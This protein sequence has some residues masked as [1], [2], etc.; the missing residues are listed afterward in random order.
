MKQ[1]LNFILKIF[2][3][4]N[5]NSFFAKLAKLEFCC[6][7]YQ[8]DSF[9]GFKLLNSKVV[10]LN[11]YWLSNKDA[12]NKIFDHCIHIE[13]GFPSLN[14]ILRVEKNVYSLNI[15]DCENECKALIKQ[16]DEKYISV[17]E[18]LRDKAVILNKEKIKALK[19][20]LKGI[21]DISINKLHKGLKY[22]INNVKNDKKNNILSEIN[23]L[24]LNSKKSK[25]DKIFIPLNTDATL[26]TLSSNTDQNLN[27]INNNNF[28]I[29]NS[30][31]TNFIINN[32][33][34]ILISNNAEEIRNEI[35][36]LESENYYLNKKNKK[37]VEFIL[38]RF[39]MQDEIL[40][41]LLMIFEKAIEETISIMKNTYND[42]VFYKLQLGDRK[43]TNFNSS[44]YKDL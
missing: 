33:D 27:Y 21:E 25:N 34:Y 15:K 30:N 26:E 12:G 11:D 37:P 8:R 4:L 9:K 22:L 3:I 35:L 6:C 44:Y 17:Q 13:K 14:N 24:N 28:N 29:N 40:T 16:F 10:D 41:H 38:D 39:T 20:K 23:L 18:S 5:F 43:R 42:M 7:I 36:K 32:E 2:I 1:A 19:T 31:R